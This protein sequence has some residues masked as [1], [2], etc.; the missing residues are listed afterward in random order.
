[1]KKH[2]TTLQKHV[3]KI[4]YVIPEDLKPSENNQ[5]Q[6]YEGIK[7]KANDLD[8]LVGLMKDK[9]KTSSKRQKIQTLTSTPPSWSIEKGK[10]EFD[11]SAYMVRKGYF[12]VTKTKERI[13][14]L[15]RNKKI[16]D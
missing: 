11:V 3:W 15:W 6:T 4:I 13:S 1:M 14:A 10:T 16:C 12:R 9:I 8:R 5:A 7:E 2:E